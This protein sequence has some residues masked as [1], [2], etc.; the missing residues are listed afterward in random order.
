MDRSSAARLR[1]RAV[2]RSYAFLSLL[3][4]APLSERRRRANRFG[5]R[6]CRRHACAWSA[7]RGRAR[8]N[9]L[10][11]ASGTRERVAC[12]WEP[13]RSAEQSVAARPAGAFAATFGFRPGRRRANTRVLAQAG[14]GVGGATV[15]RGRQRGRAFAR[16][17]G[18]QCG[19]ICDSA[20]RRSARHPLVA[21]ADRDVRVTV[22]RSP[23]VYVGDA[24][25]G[26]PWATTNGSTRTVRTGES[27]NATRSRF[28]IRPTSLASTYGV[29]VSNPAE[30]RPTRGSSCRRRDAAVV[31]AR[32]CAEQTVWHA[33]GLRRLR[34]TRSGR[35]PLAG[36]SVTISLAHGSR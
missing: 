27:G 10:R 6:A 36:A 32:G 14:G 22:V 24:A 11:P 15:A 33:A 8:G 12:V 9:V 25:D 16:W 18:A 30:R 4:Q 3:P 28:R 34:A 5:G 7:S 26:V 29:V 1:A 23:H 19:A 13:R 20:P 17:S 31:V 2:G 35:K 21:T